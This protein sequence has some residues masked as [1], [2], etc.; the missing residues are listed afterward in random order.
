VQLPAVVR[1]SVVRAGARTAGRPDVRWY[2]ERGAE[3]GRG[4]G[5][6]LRTLPLGQSLLTATVLDR[7]DGSGE[8]QWLVERTANGEFRLLRGTLGKRPRER[9][10]AEDDYNDSEDD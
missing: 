5:L 9:D 1:A 3:L 8:G 6:D 2:N 7:G 4:R 10:C